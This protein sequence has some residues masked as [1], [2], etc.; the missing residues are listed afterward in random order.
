MV[1]RKVNI[2]NPFTL[3]QRDW[4]SA[5]LQRKRENNMINILLANQTIREFLG[6]EEGQTFLEYTG[7]MVISILIV[8]LGL[9]LTLVVVWLMQF[10]SVKLMNKFNNSKD[11]KAF[12]D[13][14]DKLN[15]KQREER[16]KIIKSS[17]NPIY[18]KIM[19]RYAAWRD[20]F[21]NN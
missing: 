5:G 12:N 10:L 20:I 4:V 13:Y 15:K 16:N 19:H 11:G 3:G 21:D 2:N 18:R 14:F 9:S 1:V 7:D 17:K 6:M 8:G